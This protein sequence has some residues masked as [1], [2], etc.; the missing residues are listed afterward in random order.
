M[1][2][3]AA[4][5]LNGLVLPIGAT[6]GQRIVLDGVNGV[7]EVYDS[8]DTLVA[9][10][11]PSEIIGIHGSDDS[12]IKLLTVGG[13]AAILIQPEP[14][15][16]HL[17]GTASIL[18]TIN[19]ALG[20]NFPD[21]TLTSPGIDGRPNSFLR[22]R[23]EGQSGTPG[24]INLSNDN[25]DPNMEVRTIGDII[26]GRDVIATGLVTG[27]RVGTRLRRI[28]TNQSVNSGA[29]TAIS[30]DTEDEDTDGFIAVTSSTITIPSGLDGLYAISAQA[31]G[32]ANFNGRCFAQFAFAN[33]SGTL[34]A[35]VPASY[36]NPYN[37]AGAENVLSCT[38]SPIPLAAGNTV[39][40][41]IFHTTGVA[42][43]VTAF[44]ALTRLGA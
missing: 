15:S 13:T 25:L 4:L 3:L 16:G 32:A 33:G 23:G 1:R 5:L 9:R 24:Y 27:R 39:I 8:T 37:S 34:P 36:R 44:L 10:I 29:T 41:Q 35:G 7:I 28:A 26:C 42:V 19:V 20:E 12:Y 22:L 38:V 31:I 30:F 18:A 11:S 17:T 14:I 43:N 6:S 21:L 40:F 2:S